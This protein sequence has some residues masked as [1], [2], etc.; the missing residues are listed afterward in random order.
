MPRTDVSGLLTLHCCQ[1]TCGD[2]T[3]PN[4]V[5]KAT[6]HKPGGI[7]LLEL[8]YRTRSQEGGRPFLAAD[9]RGD[10]RLAAQFDEGIRP[11]DAGEA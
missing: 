4:P 6:S 10:V 5:P 11:W 2:K 3:A 7:Q 9:R 1:R 8:A